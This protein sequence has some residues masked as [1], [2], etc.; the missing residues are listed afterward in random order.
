MGLLNGL[1]PANGIR[2]VAVLINED[3]PPTV[4]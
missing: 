3:P 1:S 4:A 2:A